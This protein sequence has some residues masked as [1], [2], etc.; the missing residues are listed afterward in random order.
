MS[1]RTLHDGKDRVGWLAQRRNGIGGSDAAGVLCKSP[2]ASPVSVF[3]DKALPQEAPGDEPERFYWG[4]TLEPVIAE[5]YGRETGRKVA[6][7]GSL[8]QNIDRPW[9][10]VTLDALQTADDKDGPGFLEIK[11][12]RWAMTD[13]V[14]EHYWIQM[15]HQYAVTGYS[16]GSFAVLVSGCEFFWCDV[17]RDD[18]FIDNILIPEE[19][20]F[21][22]RVEN[23]GP[24]PPTDASKATTDALKR[25]FPTDNGETVI[26]PREFD[27][28]D[29]ERL[30][31]LAQE[32]SLK[33]S[34]AAIDNRL[35]AAIGDASYGVLPNG[36]T[37]TYK[38]NKNGARAL[39]APKA[40]KVGL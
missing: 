11:N 21:W 15:Q 10:L 1:W 16:W 18:D 25:L 13:G 24:T 19:A 37:F 2:W 26:L 8:L 9:Q 38:A 30:E 12:T 35:K 31:I 20:A 33:E 34:K 29:R 36:R 32:R 6:M 39:R 27:D 4:R 3:A 5:H 22:Q 17:E 40:E 14:P 23:G 28:D 7:M